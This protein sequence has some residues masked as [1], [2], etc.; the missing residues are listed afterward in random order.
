MSDLTYLGFIEPGAYVELPSEPTEIFEVRGV[1]GHRWQTDAGGREE[2]VIVENCRTG[3][4][5]MLTEFE[6]DHNGLPA[7]YVAQ[8][9]LGPGACA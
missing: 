5:V 2:I 8:E 7:L 3:R 4:L 9:S 6:H 1:I